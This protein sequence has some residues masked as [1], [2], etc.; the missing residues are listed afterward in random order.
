MH[1]ERQRKSDSESVN[2][3]DRDI[4]RGA[5]EDQIRGVKTFFSIF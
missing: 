3:I 1:T 4:G 5:N 2:Q